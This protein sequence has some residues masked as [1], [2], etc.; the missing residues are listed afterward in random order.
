MR[1]EAYTRAMRLVVAVLAAV[2]LLT[3]TTAD[4]VACPDGCTDEAAEHNTAET[5]ACAICHGWHDGVAIISP[6]PI[7]IAVVR[8]STPVP[9]LPSPTPRALDHPPRLA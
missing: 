3:V 9:P 2:V 6:Q 4:L 1:V 5:S 8:E 7:A